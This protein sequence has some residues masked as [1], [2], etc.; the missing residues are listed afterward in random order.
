MVGDPGIQG[1]SSDAGPSFHK[2]TWNLAGLNYFVGLRSAETDQLC[3]LRDAEQN[4]LKR[5]RCFSHSLSPCFDSKKRPVPSDVVRG[6]RYS[7]VLYYARVKSRSRACTHRLPGALVSTR[8]ACLGFSARRHRQTR[9]GGHKGNERTP[10][11]QGSNNPGKVF[12]RG[13]S[14]N[15]WGIL[16]SASL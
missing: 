5:V 1:L 7:I 10:R 3:Y 15:C 4:R 12:I 9:P 13:T 2:N 6:T 14:W 11:Y 16:R 8:G